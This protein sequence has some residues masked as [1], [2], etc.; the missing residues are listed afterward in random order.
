MPPTV[1]LLTDFGLRDHYVG[2]LKGAVLE[3]CPAATLVD[4]AHE[5]G[6][7]EVME[8]ALTLAAAVPSFPVGTVFLAVV[9]PGVGGARRALAAE[10]GGHRFVGPDN[11][12][13]SLALEDR[14]GARVHAITNGALFR[15]EVCPVFQGR[16]VFAPVAGRLA[17]GLT[18][19][20]VGPAISDPVSLAV[21]ALARPR[22]GEWSAVVL[23]VDRFGNL[24]TNFRK[25]DLDAIVR[26]LPEGEAGIEVELEGNSIPLARAYCDVAEG[27]LLAVLGSSGRLE[28]AVNRGNAAR[29]L[30]VA[31]GAAV[32]V[33]AAAAAMLE[34]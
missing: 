9:D 22:P 30:G 29:L 33:R 15:R 27:A 25:A 8:G 23:H 17:Q 6:A 34:L 2:A 1:A 3:A 4:V 24:T 5:I 26:A 28:I 16:D 14:P 7:H 10:A 13:L 21:P 18:L 19:E 31:R 11:G 20:D 32:T 12:L